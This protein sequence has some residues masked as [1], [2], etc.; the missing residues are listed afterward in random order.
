MAISFWPIWGILRF[1]KHLSF[2]CSVCFSEHT[3][4]AFPGLN[5]FVCSIDS[6][7]MSHR[8]CCFVTSF[9]SSSLRGHWKRI[10]IILQPGKSLIGRKEG[11]QSQFFQYPFQQYMAEQLWM[12]EVIR[13]ASL[14]TKRYWSAG[15]CAPQYDKRAGISG[16][17]AFSRI[18]HKKT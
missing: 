2:P 12:A 16:L 4:A 8:K 3:V 6:P 13:A 15:C 10:H 11:V 17:P 1:N 5:A 7:S 9:S 14:M 18:I